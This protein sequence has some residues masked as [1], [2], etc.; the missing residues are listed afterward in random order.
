[1][2][3]EVGHLVMTSVQVCVG[4]FDDACTPDDEGTDVIKQ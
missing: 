3:C 1:M 2:F 4:K